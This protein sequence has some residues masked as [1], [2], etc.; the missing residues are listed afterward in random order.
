[1]ERFLDLGSGAGVGTATLAEA[2]PG[3]RV[4]AVD[5]TPEL[6]EAVRA[7]ARRRGV[8]H[9]VETVL[10]D[11]AA[12]VPAT[13]P[14]DVVWASMVLHHLPQASRVLDDLAARSRPGGCIALS[15]FGTAGA[16]RRRRAGP[17][18]PVG[19]L[20]R[21][22]AEGL[23]DELPHDHDDD[24]DW[25]EQLQAARFESV[26]SRSCPIERPAPLGPGDRH[27]LA[28]NLDRTRRLVGERLDPADRAALDEL[29]D[30]GRSGG[31]ARRDDLSIAASRTIYVGRRPG[32]TGG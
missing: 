3:A 17:L 4:V 20:A 11:P 24:G 14:V 7:R 31:L 22:A 6:L 26:D 15:E 19:A 9:R 30:P 5:G 16:A 10:A 28:S 32:P 27:W 21:A 8:G 18:G 1:V 12:G 29:L 2:W 25:V 13:D 23:H